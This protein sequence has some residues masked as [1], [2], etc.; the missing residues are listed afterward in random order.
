MPSLWVGHT[1]PGALL[2]RASLRTRSE[3]GSRQHQP[4]PGLL[5]VTRHGTPRTETCRCREARGVHSQ[6]GALTCPFISGAT[7]IVGQK[8]E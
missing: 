6:L 1:L 2:W 3:G 5:A 8:V 7:G 4:L